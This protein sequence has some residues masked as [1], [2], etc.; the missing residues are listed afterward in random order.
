[1]LAN[2]VEII[3]IKLKTAVQHTASCQQCLLVKR[4]K[5]ARC[6][7]MHNILSIGLLHSFCYAKRPVSKIPSLILKLHDCSQTQ[8]EIWM[9]VSFM[10]NQKPGAGDLLW[11]VTICSN[12]QKLHTFKMLENRVSPPT[13]AGGKSYKIEK[14]QH[15]GARLMQ[16]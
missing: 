9:D 15:P 2:L 14:L 12:Q 1:V 6:F 3:A 8:V 4:G 7:L 10:S 16:L 5:I 13:G 11:P